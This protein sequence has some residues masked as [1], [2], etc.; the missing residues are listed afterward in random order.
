MNLQLAYFIG[1]FHNGEKFA[2]RSQ[3]FAYVVSMVLSHCCLV[4]KYR[5]DVDVARNIIN[6]TNGCYPCPRHLSGEW[7]CPWDPTLPYPLGSG[8]V[9]GNAEQWRWFVPHNMSGLVGFWPSSDQFVQDLNTFFAK[10]KDWIFGNLLPNPYYWP[11]NEPDLLAP[12]QFAAAGPQYINY[13]MYWTRHWAAT[14]YGTGADGVSSPMPLTLS[15]HL[16]DLMP[17]DISISFFS[18]AWKR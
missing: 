9:E 8:Y 14:A 18:V 13:T 4:S 17:P 12:W 3:N 1:D 16:F 2:G 11:G 7:E 5:L 15:W 6:C 10:S